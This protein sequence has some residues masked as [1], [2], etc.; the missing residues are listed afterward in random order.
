MGTAP[1]I[2]AEFYEQANMDFCA[3][4]K[5]W[6]TLLLSDSDSPKVWHIPGFFSS[7]P[8]PCSSF[9]VKYVQVERTSCHFCVGAACVGRWV[10][11]F[12]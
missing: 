12:Y 6:T 4:L 8:S 1:G 5:N 7:S 2:K 9:V 3:D 11:F 10:H